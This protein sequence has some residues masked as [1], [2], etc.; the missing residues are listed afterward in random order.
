M[1]ASNEMVRVRGIYDETEEIDGYAFGILTIPAT[2]RNNNTVI[3]CSVAGT[4]GIMD[5]PIVTLTVQGDLDTVCA[6]E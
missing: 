1:L 4:N 5:S 2:I 6:I 3:Y